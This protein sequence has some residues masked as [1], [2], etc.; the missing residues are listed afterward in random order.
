MMSARF[1]AP[2]QIKDKGIRQAQEMRKHLRKFFWFSLF[3]KRTVPS[4]QV[5]NKTYNLYLVVAIRRIVGL[6]QVRGEETGWQNE[7]SQVKVNNFL[8]WVG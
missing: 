5:Y 3:T 8:L 6:V 2:R 7:Q 4:N 1:P